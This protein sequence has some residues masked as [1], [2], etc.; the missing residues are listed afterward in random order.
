M[1]GAK[2]GASLG[3]TVGALVVGAAVGAKQQIVASKERSAA[4]VGPDSHASTAAEPAT[5]RRTPVAP[6]AA[7]AT[8][9]SAAPARASTRSLGR[10]FY[11]I[12]RATNRPG[13]G[14]PDLS[15]VRFMESSGPRNIHVAPAA[16]TRL[17]GISTSAL[18]F[19]RSGTNGSTEL[20]EPRRLLSTILAALDC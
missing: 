7:T 16:V 1:D 20:E 9:S 3:R 15:A 12:V 4:S 6:S 11:G 18:R 10:T 13:H 14:R 2:D 19:V 5:V 8:P 17:H